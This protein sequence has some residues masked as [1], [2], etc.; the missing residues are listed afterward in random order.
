MNFDS[1]QILY[2]TCKISKWKQDMRSRNRFTSRPHVKGISLDELTGL[3][4]K[5]TGL[6]QSN[7]SQ[8]VVTVQF[9]RFR[10]YVSK[11]KET[12]GIP[13]IKAMFIP[14]PMLFFTPLMN[15]I[16]EKEESSQNSS[17]VCSEFKKSPAN[18]NKSQDL[19]FS[20]VIIQKCRCV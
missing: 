3:A 17:H 12:E 9:K 16:K 8:Y 6:M 15:L 13:L 2:N 19:Y 14:R 7:F 4:C 20:I 18:K 5:K 10:H 1:M 11:D